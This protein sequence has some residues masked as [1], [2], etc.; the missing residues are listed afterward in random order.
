MISFNTLNSLGFELLLFVGFR[1][2]TLLAEDNDID[3]VYVRF[4]SEDEDRMFDCAKPSD[5]LSLKYIV[6]SRNSDVVGW[7]L[8]H[9]HRHDN[10]LAVAEAVMNS[11][12]NI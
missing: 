2:I 7:R 1:T 11:D 3:T 8:H 9:H 6:S 12:E 5:M 10:D 4:A